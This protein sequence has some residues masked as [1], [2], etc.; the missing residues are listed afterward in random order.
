VEIKFRIPGLPVAQPRQRQSF[1]RI[2]GKSFARNYTPAKHPVN[3]FKAL[4]RMAAGMAYDGPPLLNAVEIQV[5]FVFAR[6]KN[7]LKRHGTGRLPHVSKP[8][9]DNVLKALLDAL[10]GV[11]FMDDS[12]VN[13]ARVEK[14]K[15]AVGEQPHTLV[16]LI[17][18]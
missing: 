5:V 15:A 8:D 17:S 12:Q 10:N 11:V 2:G 9:L 18:E 16:R 3:D 14:W 6:P 4:A 13:V 1:A 7:V